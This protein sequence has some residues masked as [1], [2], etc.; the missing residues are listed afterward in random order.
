MVWSLCHTSINLLY[1]QKGEAVNVILIVLHV[2]WAIGITHYVGKVM[3][4]YQ[5]ET[6]PSAQF[7]AF[8]WPLW[9]LWEGL[10]G[11]ANFI[12]VLRDRFD[13]TIKPDLH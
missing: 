3:I 7:K 13:G 2:L 12:N 4:L 9:M 11:F 10:V 1:A 5:G 6:T 8:L